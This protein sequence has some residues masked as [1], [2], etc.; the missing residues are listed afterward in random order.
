MSAAVTAGPPRSGG[1]AS[2]APRCSG[3]SIVYLADL[4]LTTR[5]ALATVPSPAA[6]PSRSRY[7][8]EITSTRIASSTCCPRASAA[9]GSPLA[10][11]SWS[12]QVSRRSP[13]RIAVPLPKRLGRPAPAA[14]RVPGREPPVHRRL[15]AAGVAGVHDVVVHERARVQQLERG[16]GGENLL[17]VGAARAA[18][19]PVAERG[20]QPLPAG[21]Q[22]GH[23]VQPRQQIRADLAEHGALAAQ[24]AV[25]DA[26]D[27]LAD[28]REVCLARRHAGE[29]SPAGRIRAGR[30]IAASL[31]GMPQSTQ[32][33]P[34]DQGP[35]GRRRPVV[36]VRVHAAQDRGRRAAAV[37]GD[38]AA[39]AAAADVRVGHL[40]GGRF[41]QGPHGPGD[42]PDR[43]GDDAHPGRALHRGQPLGGRAAPRDRLVRG[44]RRAQRAGA[45][46]RP[47]GRPGRRVGAA[48]RGPELRG[49]AGPADQGVG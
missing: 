2:T 33:R 47:A 34:R 43:R 3:R 40:R 14:R 20:A 38:P 39:R 31:G 45:A 46:R 9:G 21:E 24:E 4:Y 29:T 28:P 27:L 22:P 7:W 1:Q 18:P 12:A 30:P 32:S 26:A 10:W 19:A 5:S 16:R 8:P 36:L 44:G 17:A 42:R 15:A 48:S 25:Q 49:R 13:T 11:N 6:W 23:R 37:A 41:D 35:A